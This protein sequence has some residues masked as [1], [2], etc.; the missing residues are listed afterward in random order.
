MV[1]VPALELNVT[2]ALEG[3]ITLIDNTTV[4]SKSV[5]GTM[6]KGTVEIALG[7][8]APVVLMFPEVK[9]PNAMVKLPAVLPVIV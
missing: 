5:V 6:L 2:D 3:V 4:P 7:P 8:T 9:P 1:A